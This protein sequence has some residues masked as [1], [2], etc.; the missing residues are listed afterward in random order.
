MNDNF[1]KFLQEN[2]LKLVI[3]IVTLVGVV[4][5]SYFG[6]RTAIRD[7]EFRVLAIEESLEGRQVLIQ[8]FR[9]VQDRLTR[10]EQGQIR[11]EDKIDRLVEGR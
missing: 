8:E 6:I 7:L 5:A 9:V 11:I 4:V 10:L 2:G 3:Q 1:K